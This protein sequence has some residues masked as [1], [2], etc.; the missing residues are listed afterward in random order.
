M[1]PA[2]LPRVG[3]LGIDG[4]GSWVLGPSARPGLLPSVLEDTFP[5]TGGTGAR[6][7]LVAPVLDLSPTPPR[8]PIVSTKTASARTCRD[9]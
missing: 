2:Q 9:G 8:M 3:A 1:E 7:A 4:P 5:Q 6:R